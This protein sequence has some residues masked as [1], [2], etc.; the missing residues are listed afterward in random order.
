M[1]WPVHVQKVPQASKHLCPA[2]LQTRCDVCCACQSVCSFIPSDSCM[3]RAVDGLQSMLPKTVHG[4]VPVRAVDKL[5][6][7]LPKTVH[8]CVPVRAAHPKTVHGCVPVRAA[9]PSLH[10]Y[11][12]ATRDCHPFIPVFIHTM[13]RL[14]LQHALSVLPQTGWPRGKGPSLRAADLSSTLSLPMG[15]HQSSHASDFKTGCPDTHLALQG[16]HWEWLAQ[17]H[18]VR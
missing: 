14:W 9:R 6:S 13:Q 1:V 5:Q 2:I 10:L 16:Q 7:M 3:A 8:G 12:Q 11:Q 18:W 15:F 17:C 4:C